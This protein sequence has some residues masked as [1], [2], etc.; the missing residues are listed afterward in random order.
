MGLDIRL[1]YITYCKDIVM[2]FQYL[3]P[4][5]KSGKS[6]IS[7]FRAIVLG[8]KDLIYFLEK[9]SYINSDININ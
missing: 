8:L 5:I 9:N 1:Y 3:K 2:K 6:N 7:I 4:P